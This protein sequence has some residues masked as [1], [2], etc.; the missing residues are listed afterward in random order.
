MT[1][2]LI[3]E[4]AVFQ[5]TLRGR[6]ILAA[7][8]IVSIA[9]CT[10][11]AIGFS[12]PDQPGFSISIFQQPHWLIPLFVL[13]IL[14]IATIFVAGIITRTIRPEAAMACAAFGLASISLRGG[15]MRQTLFIAGGRGVFIALAIETILLFAFVLAASRIFEWVMSPQSDETGLLS[16]DDQLLAIFAHV[17]AMSIIMIFSCRSDAKFQTIACVGLSAAVGAF[18]ARQL[19]PMDSIGWL[20]ASPLIV[21]VIGYLAAWWHPAAMEIG[22]LNGTLAPL[23]RPLPLDYLGMGVGGTIVGYWMGGGEEEIEEQEEQP[24]A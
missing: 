16:P 13:L 4:K 20:W 17:V 6:M 24:S 3:D 21:A 10:W 8:I 9:L 18:A 11:L 7:G 1:D 19:V 5:R 22:V 2:L 23:A 15:T 12:I 14:S